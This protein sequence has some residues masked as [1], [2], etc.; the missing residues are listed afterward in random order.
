[1]SQVRLGARRPPSCQQR[2]GYPNRDGAPSIKKEEGGGFTSGSGV[3]NRLPGLS[4]LRYGPKCQLFRYQR[5]IEEYSRLHYGDLAQLFTLDAYYVPDA[6][7]VG[8]I[9]DGEDLNDIDVLI[10]TE[11]RKLR[12]KEIY[13]MKKNR[14][15][16]FAAMWMQ[17]SDES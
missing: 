5:D 4:V 14:P 15:R 3:A 1:M 16:L 7:E 2:G 11:E 12:L 6:I 17:H 9:E 13:E 10:Y 8:D